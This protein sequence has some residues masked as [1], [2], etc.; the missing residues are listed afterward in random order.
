MICS[1]E[2]E[3][4]MSEE[5]TI[6]TVENAIHLIR[7]QRVMLDSDLARI[8]TS[9]IR[10]NEQ[11]RRNRKRFSLDFAFQLAREEFTNLVSQ[12]AISSSHGGR[13]KP[14][15]VFTE[16]GAIMLASVLNTPIAIEAS[17]RVVRAFV[18]LREI[19][20]TNAELAKKVSEL[21][22]RLDT[23][24]AQIAQTLCRYSAA[25]RARTRKEAGDWLS[26]KG[27]LI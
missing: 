5:G 9:T 15:W 3:A 20:S 14:P 13:R 18:H 22:R 19:I 17:I 10:L 23:H 7:G 21:E 4:P 6:K 24:D 25:A 26:R 12:N 8:G 2:V 16:H 1:L 27:A 11:C